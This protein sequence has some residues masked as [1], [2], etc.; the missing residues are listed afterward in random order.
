MKLAICDDEELCIES[1]QR[2]LTGIT[3]VKNCH[4]YNSIDILI[5]D[6]EEGSNYDVILMD[7]E[8]KGDSRNG[9][10]YAARI[11]KKYPKIQIIFMTFYNEQFSQQIFWEPVNLCGY[12]VK[13]II[14]DNFVKLLRKAQ[15]NIQ[16][17]SKQTLTVSYKGR[18]ETIPYDAI[19]YVESKGHQL[20]IVKQDAIITIYDKLDIYEKD[21]NT[22]FVRIHKSFLVN[23]SYIKRM[24]RK[25]VMLQ[26]DVILPVSKSMYSLAKDKY[27]EYMKR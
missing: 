1:I 23:M 13:P 9:I 14:K 8:W 26:N 21:M 4:F 6:M 12:L 11:N 7:I 24:D 25:E 3:E 17:K 5:K 16:N 22:E 27:F 10:Q 18:L 20:F 19:L 2:V 15:E